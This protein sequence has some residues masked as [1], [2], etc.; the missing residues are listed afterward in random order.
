[1]D[2]SLVVDE[3]EGGCDLSDEEFDG[4]FAEMT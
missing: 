4:L 3:G 1:M 2:D